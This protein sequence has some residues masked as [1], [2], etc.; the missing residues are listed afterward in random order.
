[1]AFEYLG[2]NALDY[3]YCQYSGSER[4]FRGPR[5]DLDGEYYVAIGGTETFGK[6][7]ELPFPSVLERLI[8]KPVVN[9]GQMYA[10]A[11]FFP[12]DNRIFSICNSATAA[13]IQ[14]TSAQ[15]MNNRFYSVHPRRNDRFLEP[16]S[17][18]RTIYRDVDFT[19]IHFTGHLMNVLHSRC[20]TRFNTVLSGLRSEWVSKMKSLIKKLSCPV[21]LIWMADH[22]PGP[23]NCPDNAWREP[24]FV[25]RDMLNQLAATVDQVVKIQALPDEVLAGL[26]RMI[27]NPTEEPAAEQMLGPIVHQEAARQ[28]HNAIK[29]I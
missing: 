22:A 2:A 25:D 17:L 9:L 26:D 15:N 23:M 27:F 29:A 8:Q 12:G 21:I 28:L 24:M 3:N 14:L 18:L 1:M 13:I 5:D 19:E 7:V 20:P 4:H 11:E 10:G 16:S 6:F